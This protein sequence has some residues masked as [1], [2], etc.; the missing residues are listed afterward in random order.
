MGKF[1]RRICNGKLW[2]LRTIFIFF[3]TITYLFRFQTS[4][5]NGSLLLGQSDSMST[6]DYITVY[7]ILGLC[8]S[9]SF[10]VGILLMN[11]RTITASRHLHSSIFHRVLHSTI[12]FIW[13]T[14]VGQVRFTSLVHNDVTIFLPLEFYYK[15]L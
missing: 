14:P 15:T 12:D 4:K 5:T 10:V 9:F 2:H 13:T 3:Q 6:V 11:R 1:Q 7:G 8:Q